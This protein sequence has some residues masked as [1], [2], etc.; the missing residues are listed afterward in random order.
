MIFT[1]SKTNVRIYSRKYYKQ[2]IIMNCGLV[3]DTWKFSFWS[4]ILETW[5]ELSSRM[6][7]AWWKGGGEMMVEIGSEGLLIWKAV[8][9]ICWCA[10]WF[11]CCC[12]WWCATC[13]SCTSLHDP[14]ACTSLAVQAS[15]I[16]TC[17]GH[18]HH[19][20]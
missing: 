13:R 11:C 5:Y 7:D 17:N 8:V 14:D 15:P 2:P 10:C 4:I 1:I 19:I 20:F 3:D 9:A 16:P 6:M 18:H 12:W